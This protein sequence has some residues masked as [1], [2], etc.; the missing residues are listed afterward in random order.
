MSLR[1]AVDN[2]Y[3][4]DPD[5]EP[6]AKSFVSSVGGSSASFQ[7]TNSADL[8]KALDSYVGVKF[9]IFDTHGQAGKISLSDHGKVEGLDFMLYLKNSSLLKR[10]AQLLF[11]GCN[12]GE[13]PAGDTFLD[14][15]GFYM[16]RGRGGTVGATTVTNL[17]FQAGSWSSESF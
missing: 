3:L 8:K 7:I 14:E 13:G 1:T 5:F 6:G 4:Y 2:L 10:D 17:S 12:I 9:L 11:Y 15:V 16:L